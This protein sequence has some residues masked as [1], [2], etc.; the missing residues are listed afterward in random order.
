L[1]PANDHR[2]AAF[3]YRQRRGHHFLQAR[4]PPKR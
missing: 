4:E 2:A 1:A 3:I